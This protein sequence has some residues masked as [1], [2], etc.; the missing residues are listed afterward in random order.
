MA[1]RILLTL[2]IALGL[3]AQV[4]A[5]SANG[6]WTRLTSYDAPPFTGPGQRLGHV[7]VYDPPRDRLLLHGGVSGPFFLSDLWEFP[8]ATN[9]PWHELTPAGPAPY[10]RAFHSA[11]YDPI[12]D[13]MILFGGFQP[14]A[15]GET[16]ALD[17]ADSLPLAW[18]QLA[19]TGTAPAARYWHSA[20][21]DAQFGRMAIFGGQSGSTFFNDTR[22]LVL[23]RGSEQWVAPEPVLGTPPSAR[24]CQEALF[25]PGPP[26]IVMFG[27]WSGSTELGD[28]WSVR[29]DSLGSGWMPLP[30][31]GAISPR[32][33]HVAVFD[34]VRNRMIVYGGVKGPTRLGDAWATTLAGPAA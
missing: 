14:G 29:F 28:L 18:H 22:E 33:D 25:V 12:G 2:V 6:T 15:N 21:Y 30:A 31:S 26:R 16:W 17:L 9:G 8:L 19:P 3:P 10:S 27:G 34:R 7:L 5:A 24:C 32:T 11:I 4:S 23:V 13:R 1:R 20:M